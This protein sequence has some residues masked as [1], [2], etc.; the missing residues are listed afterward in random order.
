MRYLPLRISVCVFTLSALLASG[1]K[2]SAP[3]QPAAQPQAAPSAAAAQTALQQQELAFVQNF[4]D[5]YE[6]SNVNY[7]GAIEQ[8]PEWFDGPL[9]AAFR[10]D[11]AIQ[12]KAVGEIDG[13]DYDPFGFGQDSSN[14]S[15]F[16]AISVAGDRVTVEAMDIK[17]QPAPDNTLSLQVRCTPNAC[18]IVNIVFP[19]SG[20][21]GEQNYVPAYDMLSELA[22]LHPA[23]PAKASKA[24]H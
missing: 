6:K 9:L 12:A 10:N 4:Y 22:L 11:A 24:Q 21:P 2:K 7:V 1:C 20:K 17:N 14:I 8:K 18:V 19:D 5:W 15:G 13:L 3:P 23:K 16:K